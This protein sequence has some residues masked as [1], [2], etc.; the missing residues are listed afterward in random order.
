MKSIIDLM[1]CEQEE[2]GLLSTN[3][4]CEAFRIWIEVSGKLR[5]IVTENKHLLD[6][7]D[8]SVL[9]LLTLYEER[10]YKTGV[11]DGIKIQNEI[12]AFN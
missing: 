6:E 2:N 9:E 3:L 5:D 1:L 8:D 4:E 10:G 7:L 11:R 12:K